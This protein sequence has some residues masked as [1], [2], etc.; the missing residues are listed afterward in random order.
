MNTAYIG[1][2]SNLG[3]SLQVVLDGW[4]ALGT[5]S[6]IRLGRLSNPYRTEPVGMVSDNWFINAA[7]ELK[8][9][10]SPEELLCQLHRIERMFGRQRAPAA[11]SYLDRTLDLDLLLYDQA[12]V[13]DQDV[14]VPHP[15]LQDRLFVLLP[16]SEIAADVVH[17]MMKKS[18]GDLLVALK[19]S[20]TNPSVEKIMWPQDATIAHTLLS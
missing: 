3:D 15:E 14:I 13:T 16:L 10:L 9:T 7:G 8:T 4:E 19:D 17:P 2:G 12:V 20:G 18:I 5:I 6:G 1:L 11:E